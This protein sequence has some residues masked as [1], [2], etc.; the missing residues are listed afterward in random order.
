MKTL[1]KGNPAK[2][3]LSFA[4]PIMLG[5]IFQQLY[6]IAD[7]KIVSNYVNSK[8]LGA[9][10]ATTVVTNTIIGFINGLTQGFAIP[11]AN[12]FGAGD[13]K[14]MRKYVGGSVI[15]TGFTS[16][17]LTVFAYIYIEDILRL[18]NTPEDIMKLAIEYVKVIILGII[19]TALY[20]ICA[21]MLRG[22]GDSTTPLICLIISVLLNIGLDLLFVKVMEYGVKGAAIATVIAQ[23]VAAVFCFM[24]VILR[25]R[26][27]LPQKGEW[28]VSA[29]MYKNLMTT[30][31]SMGLMSCI[32]NIGT[33]VLQ[34][35]INSLGT[36][37]VTAHTAA[38]K[39]FDIF[40]VTIFSIGISMTTYSSQNMGAGKPERVKQGVNQAT[41]MVSAI[42]TVLIAVCFIFGRPVFEWLTSSK[43][44]EIIDSAV[45][46]TRISIVFYYVLGPLFILRCTL[47]GMG[48]KVIPVLTSALEMVLKIL[49]SLLLVPALDYLGV[50]LTEPI[51][52]CFMTLVLVIS[53]RKSIREEMSNKEHII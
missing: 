13:T 48:R 41:I 40:S 42:T 45:M 44:S 24:C 11:V 9:V 3:I 15:L 12:C 51:S 32:V 33:V 37:I 25:F 27:L 35:A 21:N 47:Q 7:S 36:A 16:V 43:D 10:G 52:W 22:V 19:L 53:Y 39:I 31:L 6:A 50:S 5:Y 46:Y 23:A 30:G 20:N 2:V 28:K 38:R 4:I 29:E 34:G 49:S 18:L 8:A 1:T 14:K 17:F 26:N